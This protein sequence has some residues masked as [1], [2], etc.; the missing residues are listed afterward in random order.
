MPIILALL[1][2]LA[3]AACSEGPEDPEPAGALE[4][5]EATDF[6][7]AFWSIED[8]WELADGTLLVLDRGEGALFSLD[9]ESGEVA[10]VLQDGEGPQ[11]VRSFGNVIRLAGDTLA[12]V[13]PGNAAYQLISGGKIVGQRSVPLDILGPPQRDTL[14]HWLV[15]PSAGDAAAGG[16]GSVRHLV[17]FMEGEEGTPPDTV[18]SRE[19][20]ASSPFTAL[21]RGEDP[22]PVRDFDAR[23]HERLAPDGWVAI[24]HPDPYRVEWLDPDGQWHRGGQLSFEAVSVDA[25]LRRD[26]LE[27]LR[28]LPRE[29]E[30]MDHLVENSDGVTELPPY[31]R[32]AN[33]PGGVLF[34]PDGQLLVL[35]TQ[36]GVSDSTRY[37]VLARNGTR[38]G[39]IRLGPGERIIA[40]SP[41]ALYVVVRDEV[42]LQYLR[43]IPVN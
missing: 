12:A 9:P 6:D 25:A 28:G 42:D 8:V 2:V 32:E 33:D 19:V 15:T 37:D 17:R 13:M 24:L 1:L 14:G 22:P 3:L 7:H 35:R 31:L 39:Q 36:L 27:R 11:E 40:S 43:R 10:E 20:E 41:D 23:M 38:S 21:R 4:L 30:Q 18:R 5:S 29:G 26:I 34:A 16:G